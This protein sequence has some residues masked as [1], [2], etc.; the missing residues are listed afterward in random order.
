MEHTNAGMPADAE[1]ENQMMESAEKA[2]EPLF[3]DF[4][5]INHESGHREMMAV[6]RSVHATVRGMSA[7]E[8]KRASDAKAREARQKAEK[9]ARG[10]KAVQRLILVWS[11]VAGICAGCWISRSQAL[12]APNV[13]YFI[14]SAAITVGSYVSGWLH[15]WSKN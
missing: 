1:F 6:L 11:L 7:R 14:T 5:K 8:A 15:G 13:V 3:P 4:A 12:M 9:A 2:Q 10:K